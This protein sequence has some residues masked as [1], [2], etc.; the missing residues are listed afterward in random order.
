MC[1]WCRCNVFL[2]ELLSFLLEYFIFFPCIELFMWFIILLHPLV[3]CWIWSHCVNSCLSTSSCDYVDI[4][5]IIPSLWKNP[6]NIW[7]VMISL[8]LN[9]LDACS[10]GKSGDLGLHFIYLQ[11]DLVVPYIILKI[12]WSIYV[13]ACN[14]TNLMI[15]RYHIIIHSLAN[16]LQKVNRKEIITHNTSATMVHPL[17][18]YVHKYMDLRIFYYGYEIYSTTHTTNPFIQSQNRFYNLCEAD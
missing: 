5:S 18:G 11:L 14:V 15:N 3:L 16:Y 13:Y 2:E 12:H 1:S 10:L 8:F 9:F 7:I 4:Y 17:L 6:L